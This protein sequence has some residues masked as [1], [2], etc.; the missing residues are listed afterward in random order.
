[1]FDWKKNGRKE[2]ERKEIGRKESS[3]LYLVN[4]EKAKGKNKQEKN[5]CGIHLFLFLPNL[6]GNLAEN[7]LQGSFS[8]PFLDKVDAIVYYMKF[9]APHTL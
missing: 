7:K 1:M 6:G 9:G 5:I 2:R 4:E 3:F 8:A